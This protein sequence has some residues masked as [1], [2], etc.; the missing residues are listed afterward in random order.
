MVPE[1]PSILALSPVLTVSMGFLSRPPAS[2][3]LF[4][5]NGWAS[6]KPT[7]IMGSLWK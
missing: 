6:K 3:M 2:G 7:W 4:A 1:H 5:K